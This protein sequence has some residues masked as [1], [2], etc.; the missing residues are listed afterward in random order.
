M[1]SLIFFGCY[2]KIDYSIEIITI[3]CDDRKLRQSMF[4]IVGASPCHDRQSLS[5]FCWLIIEN[6]DSYNR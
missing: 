2:V 1:N 3:H 5:I 6:Y 4:T